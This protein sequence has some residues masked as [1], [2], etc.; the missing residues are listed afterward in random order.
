MHEPEFAGGTLSPH[1]KARGKEASFPYRPNHEKELAAAKGGHNIE[2][3]AVAEDDSDDDEGVRVGRPWTRQDPDD[4][5]DWAG[6]GRKT[7]AIKG[8]RGAAVG[9]CWP[10]AG[11]DLDDPANRAGDR[12]PEARPAKVLPKSR[13]GVPVKIVNKDGSSGDEVSLASKDEFAS[14]EGDNK[15][16]PDKDIAAAA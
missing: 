13:R 3:K 15:R 8:G 1:K 16:D 14:K 4:P 12:L 2:A 5:A 7:R 11:Q 10:K 6:D 9:T